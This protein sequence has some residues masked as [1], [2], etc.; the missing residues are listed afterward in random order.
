[1][2]VRCDFETALLEPRSELISSFVFG[3]MNVAP[4]WCTEFDVFVSGVFSNDDFTAD[5]SEQ[6]D[7]LLFVCRPFSVNRLPI[8]HTE[9][10]YLFSLGVNGICVSMGYIETGT[11]QPSDPLLGECVCFDRH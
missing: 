7:E 1:M 8:H 10:D 6:F 11:F 4:S 9:L 3:D 5:F 2:F